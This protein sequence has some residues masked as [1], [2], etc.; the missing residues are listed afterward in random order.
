[1]KSDFQPFLEEH[2][3]IIAKVCRI[4]TDTAEDFNDYYQECVIQLWRSFDS[5]RGA[6]KLS[7]WVYRVCLNV[8]LSQ[9]RNKKKIVSVAREQLPDIAEEKDVVEE[10]Q[11]N[12]LY[13]AIKLLKE[14]DRAVILLYLEEKSYK[15]MAEILGITVTNVGA[16]VNR[17]KNQLKKI[18][19]GRTGY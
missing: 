3:R 4:Y 15:E 8:C 14:S 10:E 11:L 17:V 12:M 13:K 18:I 2:H 5:F 1:M 19:D 7:T 6:S 9:L 16:K